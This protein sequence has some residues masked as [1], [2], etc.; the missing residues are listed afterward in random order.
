[1]EADPKVGDL[2]RQE[3]SLGDAEDLARVLSLTGTKSVPFT[4]CDGDRLVTRD[5]NPIEPHVFEHKYYA[6]GVG[7]IADLDPK[8]GRRLE[9]GGAIHLLVTL[10]D[11]SRDQVPLPPS[12][13]PRRPSP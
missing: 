7:V 1:M 4:S 6:P 13:T 8:T 5:F 9:F 12:I 2:Y 3:S 11:G 10:G